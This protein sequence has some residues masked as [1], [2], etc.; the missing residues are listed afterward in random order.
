MRTAQKIKF[1][2]EN[3]ETVFNM[4]R[5]NHSENIVG[6]RIGHKKANGKL[7]RNF[8]FIFHV[9]KKENVIEL[10]EKQ[11]IPK[12]I[13]IK[14]A[15][16]IIRQIKTDVEETGS[17]TLQS[18]IGD[19]ITSKLSNDNSYGSAGVFVSDDGIR[20][21]AITNYHVVAENL[22]A[23]GQTYYRRSKNNND[24]NV[25]LKDTT[26]NEMFGL[27]EEG[28]IASDIDVA[29]VYLPHLK[30][31]ALINRLANGQRIQGRVNI[32]E[33][34]LSYK[35]KTVMIFSFHNPKGIS[36]II[37]NTSARIDD[38]KIHFRELLQMKRVTNPG[39]SGAILLTPNYLVLGVIIG[40]DNYYSYAIPF[41]KVERFKTFRII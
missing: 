9:L 2:N 19:K 16:G 34:P 25:R 13:S 3:I 32:N 35:G 11:L 14:F 29:F 15:D 4:V 6:I 36:T 30:P 18:N 40:A 33:V 38:G 10:A 31:T 23:N 17:F 20:T 21:M 24:L 27:F 28:R 26:G 1:L 41:Y 37:T 12:V 5:E 22:I 39:D 7:L 8:S